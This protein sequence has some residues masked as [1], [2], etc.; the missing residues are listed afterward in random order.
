[1]VVKSEMRGAQKSGRASYSFRRIAFV[2]FSVLAVLIF[3]VPGSLR[4]ASTV[5]LGTQTVA[6]SVD[7]DQ[8]GQ[9]EAFQFTAT[10][11]GTLGSLSVYLDSSSRS[12]QL[13]VGLYSSSGQNPGALLT[14][15]SLAGPKAGAWNTIAV[16]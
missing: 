6:N 13:I 9:A 3:V 8:A 1:M 7:S 2:I 15:A 5:L 12:T 14:Q 11:G 10:A 16:P 4:A